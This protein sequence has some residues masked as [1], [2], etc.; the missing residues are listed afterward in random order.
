[1]P[2]ASHLNYHHHYYAKQIRE[3]KTAIREYS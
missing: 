3:V 1:M 2:A